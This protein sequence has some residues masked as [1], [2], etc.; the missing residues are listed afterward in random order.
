MS[1][2]SS[3]DKMQSLGIV[4]GAVGGAVI[5]I[6]IV[7]LLMHRSRQPTGQRSLNGAKDPLGMNEST[8][9]TNPL[10]VGDADELNGPTAGG[11][12]RL[13][14]SDNLYHTHPLVDKNQAN[15]SKAATATDVYMEPDFDSIYTEPDMGPPS[16]TGHRGARQTGSQPGGP[17]LDDD[18]YLLPVTSAT[19]DEPAP[20]YEYAAP[21]RH[22]RQNQYQLPARVRRTENEYLMPDPNGPAMY[23]QLQRD[24][25]Q[26]QY[27]VPEDYA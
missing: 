7:V 17:I 15:A 12:M 10:F 25:S 5:L 9:A 6:L 14:G 1:A 26:E 16:K 11:E 3:T 4:L 8:R 20:A 21:P 24:A 18:Q 19:Y 13:A 27:A 23:T 22:A 2:S